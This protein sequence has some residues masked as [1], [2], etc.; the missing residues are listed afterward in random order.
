MAYAQRVVVE[1]RRIP[2]IADAVIEQTLA[3]PTLLVSSHRAFALGAGLTESNIADNAL[4]T[5]SGSG[6]VAPTYWL[7]YKTGVS[8]LVNLQTPQTQM[9]SM[10]DLETIP[11]DQG[12]GDPNGQATQ[13]LGSLSQIAQVGRPLEVSHRDIAPV[14]DIYASNAGRDLGRRERCGR[15]W[16]CKRM[17]SERTARRDRASAGAGVTMKGGGIC[18]AVGG[19]RILDPARLSRDCRQLPVSS[20]ILSSSSRP[21]RAR[22]PGSSGRCS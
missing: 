13:I 11:I 12:D 19:A 2:G 8:H 4:A 9:T 18:A 10:N 16:Y 21:C 1:M 7:D 14:I 5:L 17:K 20:S 6:Q 15:R 22:S 3:Q